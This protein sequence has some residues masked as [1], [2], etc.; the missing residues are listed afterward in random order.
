MSNVLIEKI[1]KGGKIKAQLVQVDDKALA[2]NVEVDVEGLIK[3]SSVV[4]KSPF[5]GLI[6]NQLVETIAKLDK[7]KDK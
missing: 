5:L 7:V 2:V 1:A 3:E 4:K 6:A